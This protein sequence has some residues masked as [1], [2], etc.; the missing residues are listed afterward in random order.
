M[1]AVPCE[2]FTGT[3]RP[4]LQIVW[5]VLGQSRANSRK[6]DGLARLVGSTR[7][8]T[9]AASAAFRR[10][11]DPGYGGAMAADAGLDAGSTN[12]SPC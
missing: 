4:N 10:A 12:G 11:M 9:S 7:S 2:T 1:H 6:P 3:E 5:D 8:A